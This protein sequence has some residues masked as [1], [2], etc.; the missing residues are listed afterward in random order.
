MSMMQV[1]TNFNVPPKGSAQY[2]LEKAFVTGLS[3]LGFLSV[4]A[5]FVNNKIAI[6][7]LRALMGIGKLEVPLLR[8]RVC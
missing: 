5:G 6:I 3:F 8:C 1:R 2:A 4:G 7:I